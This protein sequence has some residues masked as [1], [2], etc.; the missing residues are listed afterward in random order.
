MADQ[1]G[2]EQ[3]LKQIIGSYRCKICCQG[4][5]RELVRVAARYEELWIVSVRCGR[6]RNTQLFYVQMRDGEEDTL[7]ENLTPRDEERQEDLPPISTDEILD[8]H[9][10]LRGFDGDFRRLFG[11]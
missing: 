11:R 7:L 2:Q 9:Q 8:M 1:A 4:Y 3:L 10:F 6:C 5:R